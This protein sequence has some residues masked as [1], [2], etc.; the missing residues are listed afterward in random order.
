MPSPARR[1]P[2]GYTPRNEAPAYVTE[3][4]KPQLVHDASY[5]AALA[6]AHRA[7]PGESVS[8]GCNATDWR[9]DRYGAKAPS[10]RPIHFCTLAERVLAYLDKQPGA[11]SWGDLRDRLGNSAATIASGLARSGKVQRRRFFVYGRSGNTSQFLSLGRVWPKLPPGA[12]GVIYD[13][14][15][16]EDDHA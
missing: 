14:T 16:E 15:F 12:H 8:G 13:T 10:V 1:Y 7:A 9:Q 11:V 4:P 3:S 2:P 5:E 6:R